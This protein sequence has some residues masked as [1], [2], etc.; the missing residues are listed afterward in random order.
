MSVNR[1]SFE[2]E[3]YSAT[4]AHSTSGHPRHDHQLIFPLDEHRLL[5][6][7]C[8]YYVRN[9]GLIWDHSYSGRHTQDAAPCQISGRVSLD[10][11]RHWSEP[12]TLQ[13]NLGADNV[14][15]PNLLRISDG[16]LLFSYTQRDS[17]RESLRVF[18]RF[19]DDQAASWSAPRQISPDRGW[20]FTNADHILLHSSGRIILLCHAGEIYGPGDHY[21]AL[22][23]YSDDSGETWQQSRTGADLPRRGAEEPA[24]VERQDGSLLALLRTSLGKLYR[25]TS[26]DRGETWSTPQE[27]SLAAP[28]A[29]TCMKRMPDG[30]LLL[31]WN[32]TPPFGETFPATG[33]T[34]QPRNPLVAAVSRDDGETWGD[35]KIVEQRLGYDHGYPSVSFIGEEAFV[36][37]YSTI[38]SGL[39]SPGC[40]VRLKVYPLSW[41]TSETPW[42]QA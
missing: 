10:A 4:L 11:G 39:G 30:N 32:N 3:V 25:C 23:L 29:A 22:C 9:P 8:A 37:Y 42:P 31:I 17:A 6:V 12:F 41:F 38:K 34:H 15:H 20:Y 40:E 28:S 21:Q 27:T 5:F 26:K 36:T 24:V 33:I 7:W 16:R 13:E 2:N 14:K 35:F 19:S 18:A 1:S